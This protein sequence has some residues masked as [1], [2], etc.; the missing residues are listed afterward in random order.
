[1][2]FAAAGYNVRLFDIEP[3]QVE[4]A[5][6][7]IA[8]ELNKLENSKLLRGSKSASEQMALISGMLLGGNF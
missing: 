2:L 6:K 5:L 1:M 8:M 4:S 7:E 3:K